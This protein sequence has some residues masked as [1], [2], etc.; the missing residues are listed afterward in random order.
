MKISTGIFYEKKWPWDAY[1]F[2][3]NQRNSVT[4]ELTY[5]IL[6]ICKSSNQWS[7]LQINQQ[8]VTGHLLA[9]LWWDINK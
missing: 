9:C 8:D 3:G 2:R 4:K 5:V 6:I 7:E 1:N